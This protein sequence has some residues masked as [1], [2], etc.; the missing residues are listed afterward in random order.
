MGAHGWS[1]DAGIV[2]HG[3]AALEAGPTCRMSGSGGSQEPLLAE[4]GHCI[5]WPG[6]GRCKIMETLLGAFVRYG[7]AALLSWSCAA[8]GL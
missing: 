6:G 1:Y 4:A 7:T 3:E 2:R 8:R 5:D